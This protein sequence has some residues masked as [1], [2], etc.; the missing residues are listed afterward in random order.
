MR[1]QVKSSCYDVLSVRDGA[2]LIN[3]VAATRHTP[4]GSS[5]RCQSLL[6]DRSN[7]ATRPSQ[8][9]AKRPADRK[10]NAGEL[11]PTIV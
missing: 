6:V 10:G 11:V 4:G 7:R 3:H 2:E 1:S 9:C 8:P 5:T